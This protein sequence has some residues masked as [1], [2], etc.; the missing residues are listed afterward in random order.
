[1]AIPKKTSVVVTRFSAP[2]IARRPHRF[3][4]SVWALAIILTTITVATAQTPRTVPLLG[5]D[6]QQIG[7]ATFD[8][9]RIYLRDGANN[10]FAQIVVDADG[11][12]TMYD[13]NG[14]VLDRIAGT[15]PKK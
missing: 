10:L 4:S 5:K 14:K 1:M 8:G 11:T 6:Q 13:A 2:K 3:R 12:R 9:N 7:T 15:S